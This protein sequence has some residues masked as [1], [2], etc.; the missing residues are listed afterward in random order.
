MA[1]VALVAHASRGAIAQ[2]QLKIAA[3]VN[4]D[5]IP[6]LD[7]FMRLRMSM[8]AAHLQDSPGRDSACCRR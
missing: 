3:V 1:L 5:V 4:D 2:D 6:E 7:V 8:L